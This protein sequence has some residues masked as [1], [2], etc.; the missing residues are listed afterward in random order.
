MPET[1]TSIPQLIMMRRNQ[2]DKSERKFR[3]IFGIA[4][5][6]FWDKMFG[7]DIIK[8]DAWLVDKYGDFTA[9]EGISTKQ[10]I[11][12]EYGEE[13]ANLAENLL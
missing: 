6:V 1:F 7:L 5:S 13:A 4:L 3:E 9:N 12:R 10:F 8:F 2:Y 11:A